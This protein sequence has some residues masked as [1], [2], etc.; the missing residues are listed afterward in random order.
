M[1]K[2]SIN[3]QGKKYLKS[4][5]SYASKP[6]SHSLSTC[7]FVTPRQLL[8]LVE[9]NFPSMHRADLPVKDELDAIEAVTRVSL[10]ICCQ[11]VWIA[12]DMSQI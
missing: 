4:A 12:A 3:K 11:K 2:C 8:V 6:P 1:V 9:H 7:A 5:V 10:E